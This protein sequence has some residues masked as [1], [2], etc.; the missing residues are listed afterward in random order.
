MTTH[1]QGCINVAIVRGY[2]RARA[3]VPMCEGNRKRTA[4]TLQQIWYF[5]LISD[6]VSPSGL[7]S[8][9]NDRTI[10]QQ[11]RS[12]DVSFASRSNFSSRN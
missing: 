10:N 8:D 6:R 9:I 7:L 2:V 4:D 3:R 12:V 5:Q 1:E 11:P